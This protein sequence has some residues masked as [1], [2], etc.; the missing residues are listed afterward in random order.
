MLD[1]PG[2]EELRPQG[3]NLE[4]LDGRDFVPPSDSAEPIPET[5]QPQADIPRAEEA[6]KEVKQGSPFDAKR[7]SI[8]D[9][10]RAQRDAN[11]KNPTI[12]IPPEMERQ[13]V[14]PHVATREDRN[15]PPAE[16]V[17]QQIEENIPAPRRMR[18][19]VNGVE[20]E[21]D[22]AQVIGYAQIALASQDALNEAKTA[23]ERAKAA[24]EAATERLAAVE[25]LLAN[26]SQSTQQQPAPAQAKAE[27]TKP[28]TDEELD[29]I[30]D[31]I[32]TGDL[33]D[34]ANALRKF[35]AQI[36]EK[37]KAD[38]G[39]VRQTVAATIRQQQ[40]E[41]RVQHETQRVIDA[42]A[43]ENDDL[44][45]NDM[46]MKV[47]IDET[48]EVMRDNLKALGVH[49]DTITNISR[50][51]GVAPQVAVGMATRMLRDKGY[52]LDD[53]AAVMRTAAKRVREGF[54]LTA[55]VVRPQ[56][57]HAADPTPSI[58]AERVE[59]K[60]AMA[61]QPRRANIAPGAEAA[62]VKTQ[63]QRRADAVANMRAFRRGR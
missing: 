60:Q 27:D 14:G 25:R 58:M 13:Q 30:I 63:E 41:S 24:E 26:H 44:A 55:P 42:F 54:G 1:M 57:V 11:D 15:R 46:R 38:L 5:R 21:Y 9:K 20:G 23:R 53:S 7:N 8:V 62:P 4:Q 43:A 29:E 28:A 35:G 16:Q 18:L 6:P 19:K 2:D 61:P 52:Q 32:Q 45:S 34:A 31:Q 37:A 3:D 47:L 48:V 22:E 39:D 56:P 17:A 50:K 10:I 12:D 40:E 33:K 36:L 51:F 59:R 49:D